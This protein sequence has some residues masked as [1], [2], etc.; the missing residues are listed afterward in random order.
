MPTI[1]NKTCQKPI[2]LHIISS[3]KFTTGY[4]N[5]M[6]KEV[7]SYNHFFVVLGMFDET[8]LINKNNVYIIR[9][10]FEILLKGCIRTLVNS[11][12]KIIVS[13]V[14]TSYIAVA[15]WKK[16]FLKKTFLH[17]WG[18][19]FYHLRKPAKDIRTAMK[20]RLKKYCARNCAGLLFLIEG[21]YDNF[22]EITGIVNRHYIAP[23][24]GD[25][26]E[27]I[28]YA[29]YRSTSDKTEQKTHI[30]ILV[31]N[32]A[33]NTNQHAEVFEALGKYPLNMM[34]IYVP[35]SYGSPVYREFVLKEGHR[36]LGTSFH[37]ML[38]FMSKKEY[39]S[40]LAKMDIG[41]FNNDRQQGM[42]NI[43]AM[44]G[45]GKKVFIRNDTSM[46]KKYFNEGWAIYSISSISNLNYR[47]FS[48]FSEEDR[49]KN[50]LLDDARDFGTIAKTAWNKVFEARTEF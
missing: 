17:F 39:I 40:F 33:T 35:L 34:N 18:G 28:H 2:V 27:K 37:P 20:I 30:N 19:D 15:F 10:Y 45:L 38:D 25:P 32:S 49:Q 1:E 24:P 14:F 4:I 21:E 12:K 11:S 23:M 47:D 6:T 13:G 9:D 46:W 48:F 44:L 29:A 8:G 16:K 50:E 42:G 41:I 3:D 22:H 43:N 31:G 5:F 26:L 7:P 36:L